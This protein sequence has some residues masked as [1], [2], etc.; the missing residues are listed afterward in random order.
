M[1]NWISVSDK[2]PELHSEW[3]NVEPVLCINCGVIHIGCVL[4]C[5]DGIALWYEVTSERW[6]WL[7]KGVTHWMPLPSLP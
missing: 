2:L 4:K 1:S 3:A 5:T 7:L 6:R